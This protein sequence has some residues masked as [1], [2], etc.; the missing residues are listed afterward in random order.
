ME[1]VVGVYERIPEPRE[2]YIYKGMRETL[3]MVEAHDSVLRVCDVSSLHQ[4]LVAV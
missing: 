2:P 4:E 3:S 1:M